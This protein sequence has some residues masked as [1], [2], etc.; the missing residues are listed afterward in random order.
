MS[1]VYLVLVSPD[2]SKTLDVKEAT[3][4][5]EMPA[6]M[7]ND[8]YNLVGEYLSNFTKLG[9]PQKSC[10]WVLIARYHEYIRLQDKEIKTGK[11]DNDINA[12]I[13]ANSRKEAKSL[14]KK[15]P[16]YITDLRTTMTSYD[17]DGEPSGHLKN[18]D[19]VE[20]IFGD[21]GSKLTQLCGDFVKVNK[22]HKY[23]SLLKGC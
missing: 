22:D 6:K 19:V 10:V 23:F 7:N 12:I 14:L 21:V 11:M 3:S 8:D 15:H 4:F 13:Y 18:I 20:Y 2:G 9:D 16:V 1:K 5:E 17:E